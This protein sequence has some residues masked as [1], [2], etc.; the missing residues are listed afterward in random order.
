MTTNAEASEL[1]NFQ[2]Q[3]ATW[4]DLKGPMRALHHINPARM[5]YIAA[6]AGGVAG[7]RAL[8]VGCGGGLATE[9]LAAHGA[10]ATGIDLA[11]D[12]LEVARLHGLESQVQASYRQISAEDLAAEVPASFDLVCCL[13]MLEHVPDPA[14][15]IHAVAALTKP[16]GTV[17]LSTINRHPKAFALVIVGA[18]YL[19]N[20][21]PRG[22]HDY[23]KFIKPSELTAMA[24]AAGLEPVEIKG[25]RYNPLTK[26]ATMGEDI[27]VNYFLHGK[28]PA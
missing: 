22:T 18:E 5:R 26:L 8:D 2:K 13:E 23:A 4:W 3:A 17:V 24:R 12:V 10:Q 20:L 1:A 6:C 21:V 27:D 9:W 11:S 14:S 28:K 16:G 15:V 7:K 25:L 19:T